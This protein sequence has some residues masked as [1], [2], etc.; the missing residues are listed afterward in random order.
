MAEQGPQFTF[1]DDSIDTSSIAEAAIA[2]GLTESEANIRLARDGPNEIPEASSHPILRLVKKFWGLSAWMLEIIAGLSLYLHKQIDFWIALT[3]LFVNAILGF[4]Q[5]Q[6]AS[7][8]VAALRRRLHVTART[9]R[10]GSWRLIP[11]RELVTGDIVRL[12]AGDFVPADMRVIDGDLRVDQSAL[13]GESVEISRRPDDTLYSGSIVRSG[14]ATTVVTA[15]GQ[16]TYFGRTAHLIESARPRLHIEDITGRLVK[17]LFVIVGTL[18]GISFVLSIIQGLPLLDILPLSLVLLM[19]AVPVALPVMF[20]VSTAIGTM[21]LGR[22]GVLVTHLAAVE[23]TANMDVLCADKTGTLTMNRLALSGVLVLPGFTEDD[24]VRTAAIASNQANQD[25]ID[26]AFLREASERGLLDASIKT[27]SFVPFSPQTRRT[28]SIVNVGGRKMLAMKGALRT[29]AELTG[30]SPEAVAELEAHAEEKAPKGA[31]VL[32]VACGD[33]NASLQFVG[34]AFLNDTPRPDSRRLIE[35]LRSLGVRVKMLTGDGLP[36]AR[37]I[38]HQ[39]GLGEIVRAPDLRAA[40]TNGGSR[41]IDLAAHSEGFA[42]V[43]PEDKFLVVKSLQSAGHVVGMTGDGVNDAPALSQAEVGIAVSGATDVAKG[44]ASIVLTEEGLASIVDLVKIGRSIYQ[45]VLT[46]IINK[47]SRTIL[48]AGFVVIAFLITGKFVISAL[49]MVLLVFMTDFVKIALSTDHVCPSQTPE[50][51]QIGP[52]VKVAVILG[53]LMLLEALGLLAIGLRIFDLSGNKL[54]TFSFLTLL[55][56]A[57]FSI[58]SIRERRAFWRSRPGWVLA[59]ALAAD[60][61]IGSAIGFFGLP[62]LSPLSLGQIVGTATYAL[63]C[64]LGLNDIVKS[65]LINR[66]W[67]APRR[68]LA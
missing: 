65:I 32:A 29:I 42:E 24:V 60:A 45:R 26:L 28:E 58:V 14:E 64:S 48:K 46:W 21:E 27:M 41:A 19:S 56:F 62:G 25:Q 47:V 67:I 49:G 7:S 11:A 5:E 20:T 55:F 1:P 10:D 51:W 40:G 33:M 2:V 23:D 35:Q 3:L 31:R 13:T 16:R 61:L 63:I 44:A 12:R 18:V 34:L 43:F 54:H 22:F 4:L 9:R 66:L 52:L 30:I 59:I 68:I 50:S 39:L 53:L 15:T 6:R 8:A 57:L 37:E 36:V 38:A 17:W